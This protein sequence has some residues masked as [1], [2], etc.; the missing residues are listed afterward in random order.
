MACKW[1]TFQEQQPLIG[2]VYCKT[3]RPLTLDNLRAAYAHQELNFK[4][5]TSIYGRCMYPVPITKVNPYIVNVLDDICPLLHE[6]HVIISEF[7]DSHHLWCYPCPAI[8]RRSCMIGNHQNASCYISLLSLFNRPQISSCTLL[9]WEFEPNCIYVIPNQKERYWVDCYYK[10]NGG[11]DAAVLL[12]RDPYLS[13]DEN[14]YLLFFVALQ[15]AEEADNV[16]RFIREK[17]AV[18][19][20]LNLYR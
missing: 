18:N 4:Q 13:D 6:L 7:V 14:P 12:F 3:N 10:R 11:T 16:G 19:R 1:C 5:R 15:T 17:L 8:P 2:C 9:F 20:P